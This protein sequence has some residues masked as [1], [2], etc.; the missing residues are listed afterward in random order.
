M[1][2]RGTQGDHGVGEPFVIV[3][4]DTSQWT[5]GAIIDPPAG[6]FHVGRIN[7]HG[8]K[9]LELSAYSA[10]AL[11][12]YFDQLKAEKKTRSFARRIAGCV[13][14]RQSKAAREGFSAG[15]GQSTRSE[16]WR[17]Q[18]RLPGPIRSLDFRTFQQRWHKKER[19]PSGIGW[20]VANQSFL[21]R[22]TPMRIVSSFV[23]LLQVF[24]LSMTER[25]G[26]A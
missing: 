11:R 21:P 10:D 17:I 18:L 25:T 8:A 1:V 6:P 16:F 7:A 2:D 26:R 15:T 9:L 3:G 20:I 12:T 23:P 22:V 5:T 24:Y 14:A 4:A 19:V 13:L